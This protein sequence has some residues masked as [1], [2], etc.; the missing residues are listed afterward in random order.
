MAKHRISAETPDEYKVKNVIRRVIESHKEHP[1]HSRE[2]NWRQNML[3]A[4]CTHLEN[5]NSPSH[6]R[7][8]SNDKYEH[9]PRFL[10][11]KYNVPDGWETDQWHSYMHTLAGY[12][13]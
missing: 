8:F 10:Y 4:L 9:T 2:E 11:Y 1:H 3:Y 5:A 6:R 12:K 13:I 7:I